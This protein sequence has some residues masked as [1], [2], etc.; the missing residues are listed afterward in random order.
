LRQRGV[1]LAVCRAMRIITLPAE[2]RITLTDGSMLRVWADGYQEI[3]RH[4]TFGILMDAETDLPESAL[5][6]N[7][8][9]SDPSRVVVSV[10][11]LP[12]DAV[13]D[14]SGG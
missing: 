7:V 13:G 14:I 2:W 4:Y 6:T 1:D 3:D 8:T 10:A 9:P 5:V 12:I 11:R